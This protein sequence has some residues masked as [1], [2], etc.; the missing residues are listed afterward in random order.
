MNKLIILTF[1]KVISSKG[2][3]LNCG[4]GYELAETLKE[5]IEIQKRYPVGKV[6]AN[7]YTKQGSPVQFVMID[8]KIVEEPM[9]VSTRES[10]LLEFFS[11]KQLK[12][13][14]RNLALHQA[15]FSENELNYAIISLN[16]D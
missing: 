7:G 5:A 3:L 12:R 16:A 15:V 14:E 4:C 6:L 11:K 13:I 2:F 9:D 1:Y 10:R 8:T